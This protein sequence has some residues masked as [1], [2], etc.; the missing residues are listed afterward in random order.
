MG[1]HALHPLSVPAVA[2]V[3][4]SCTRCHLCCSSPRVSLA[5]CP[6]LSPPPAGTHSPWDTPNYQETRTNGYSPGPSLGQTSLRH[7]LH[8]S[9]EGP[10][11]GLSPGHPK[12]IGLTFPFPLSHSLVLSPIPWDHFP[13]EMTCL[14]VSFSGSTF[15][16]NRRAG[17]RQVHNHG[18]IPAL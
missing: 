14:Q 15:R 13:E 18:Q 10:P 6:G 9:S 8:G 11:A 7:D 1:P 12:P 16:G 2:A 3:T 5:I 17:N 4:S